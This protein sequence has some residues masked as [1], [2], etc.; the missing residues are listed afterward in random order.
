MFKSNSEKIYKFVYENTSNYNPT[1]K[2]ILLT[3]RTPVQAVKAFN[4]MAGNKLTNIVEFTEV[5]SKT[6]ESK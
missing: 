5:V 3:A 2:T 6:E 4:R 1:K